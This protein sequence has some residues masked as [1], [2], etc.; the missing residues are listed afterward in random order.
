MDMSLP[1]NVPWITTTEAAGILGC[2]AG[3]VRQLVM[4]GVLTTG[5]KINP[6]LTMFDEREIVQ[7][8]RIVHTK[9]RPRKH[10]PASSK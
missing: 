6:R 4:D 9:G 3:R 10:P 7:H 5:R 2:T 8:S 1:T